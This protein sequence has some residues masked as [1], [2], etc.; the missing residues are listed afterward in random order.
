MPL[1]P[2]LDAVSAV[3]AVPPKGSMT[4]G[5]A[6]PLALH[7]QVWRQPRSSNTL[8]RNSDGPL[9]LRPGIAAA[10]APCD[11]PAGIVPT[12][13]SARSHGAPHFEQTPRSL[14]P[15]RMQG[16]TRLGGKVAKWAPRKGAVAMV[17]TERLLRVGYVAEPGRT[18][19]IISV[20]IRFWLS[21]ERA[22]R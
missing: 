17:Q 1:R 13:I 19:A 12:W 4:V 18:P 22:F 3:V 10:F 5:L 11:A 15:A 6:M 9:S 20:G 14:V 8:R 7:E 21:E 16:S 2:S